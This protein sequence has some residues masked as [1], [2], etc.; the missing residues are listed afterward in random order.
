MLLYSN[1]VVVVA[2]ADISGFGQGAG[3]DR[4]NKYFDHAMRSRFRVRQV[5]LNTKRNAG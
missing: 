2:Q 3:N 1:M 4:A 5:V